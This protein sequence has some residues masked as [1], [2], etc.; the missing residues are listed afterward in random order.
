MDPQVG[1]DEHL[2]AP[3]VMM[4]D[5]QLPSAQR[6]ESQRGRLAR[7]DLVVLVHRDAP[8]VVMRSLRA[9]ADSMG[10]NWAGRIVLVQNASPASTARA[11]EA[12]PVGAFPSRRIVS[13]S[14]RRNLGYAAGVNGVAHTHR[15]LRRRLQ[16]RRCHPAGDRGATRRRA[17]DDGGVF[18]AG[19]RTVSTAARKHRA[20]PRPTTSGL[21]SWNRDSVPARAIPRHRWLRP[22]LLHVLRRRRPISASP[23]PRVEIGRGARGRVRPRPRV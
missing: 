2:A 7:V 4:S 18:M 19:A 5:G 16:S 9:L 14:S 23:G 17:D 21:A 1:G 8:A 12:G 20:S 6:P 13:V 15:A 22:R 11:A 3:D 10:A